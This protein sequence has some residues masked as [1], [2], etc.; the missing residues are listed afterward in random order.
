[1]AKISVIVPVHNSGKTIDKCV[2]SILEQTFSELELILVDN[3]SKDDSL[4]KCNAWKEKDGRVRV[5]HTERSGVSLARNLGLENARGEYYCFV[6]SD[7]YLDLT[8]CEKTYRKALETG[9]EMTFAKIKWLQDGEKM[10][11]EDAHLAEAVEQRRLER[12]LPSFPEP[13]LGSACRIM[14]KREGFQAVRFDEQLK[15]Y[16]DLIYLL[17]CLSICVKAAC[18]DEE[19][20]V[21]DVPAENYYSKYYDNNHIKTC[22][23]IA[24][25]LPEILKNFGLCEYAKAEKFSIYFLVFFSILQ[26]SNDKSRSF[27]ELSRSQILKECKSSANC[28]AYTK[29]YCNTLKSKIRA[30]AVKFKW[31]FLFEKR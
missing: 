1:M 12:F 27:K 13:E 24:T 25:V 7:D 26:A 11:R 2:S 5:V 16:E 18:V 14:Y 6:D 29:L 30:W 23:R 21:Y 31:T 10:D 3:G 22:E 17:E 20:Y 9:A 4:D 28:K 15:I 19:L 8:F